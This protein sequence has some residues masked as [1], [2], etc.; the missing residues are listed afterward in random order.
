MQRRIARDSNQ[1]WHDHAV[2][3]TYKIYPVFSFILFSSKTP[4]II[5]VFFGLFVPDTN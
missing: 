4:S 3:W 2:T 5:P 1:I